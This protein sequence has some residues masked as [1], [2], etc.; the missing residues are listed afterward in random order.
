MAIKTFYLLNTTATAPI[1]GGSLQD[2]GSAPAAA[3][4]TFG[5]TVGKAAPSFPYTAHEV[6]LN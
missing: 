6:W 1:W 5:G 4:S 2:G 3:S